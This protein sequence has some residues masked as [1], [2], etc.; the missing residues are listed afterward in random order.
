MVAVQEWLGP[1]GI[2]AMAIGTALAIL[3]LRRK[4]SSDNKEVHKDKAEGGLLDKTILRHDQAVAEVRTLVKQHA[5]EIKAAWK[6]HKEDAVRIA[7]LEAENRY[8][9]HQLAQLRADMNEVGSGLSQLKMEFRQSQFG[10]L[11]A[12]G[13][14]RR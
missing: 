11:P 6:Q 2:V 5:D 9:A 4:F 1:G 10:G 14:G 8:Q 13:E 12:S 7:S 3:G